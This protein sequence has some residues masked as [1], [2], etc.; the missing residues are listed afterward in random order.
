M[1]GGSY[2]HSV[3]TL[4]AGAVL[5]SRLKGKGCR[6]LESNMRVRI[7]RSA[8]YVYPDLSVVCGSPQFDLDDPKQ[9]TIL[10]PRVIFE[11]LSESTEAYD[12]G[13]KFRLYRQ[14]ESMREYVLISQR[15]PLV[16]TFA[17]QDDGAWRIATYR[18]L[19][20]AAKFTS[21]QIDVPLA[22]LYVDIGF[23]ESAGATQ[24]GT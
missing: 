16:E 18:G 19:E 8:R 15:E 24:T 4:N 13:E 14:I 23:G 1:A 10:N 3:I 17:R 2:H 21:L 20:A 6:P 22:E 11:V 12:R 5:L 9:T 7:A